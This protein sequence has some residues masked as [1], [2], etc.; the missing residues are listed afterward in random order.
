MRKRRHKQKVDTFP[1]LAVLLCAMGSLILV[2]LVMDRRAKLAAKA[3]VEQAVAEQIAEAA[4]HAEE[5]RAGLEKKRREAQQEWERKREAL[6]ARLTREQEEL[7]KQIRQ[8]RLKLEEAAARLLADGEEYSADTRRVAAEKSRLAGAEQE[9]ANRTAALGKTASEAEATN[10]SLQRMAADLVRAEETLKALK[11]ARERERQ[12]YSVVPYKGRHGESRRPLYIECS[13]QGVI[14]HPDRVTV[15]PGL[16]PT[17]TRAEVDRRVTRQRQAA[18]AHGDPAQATPYLLVLIRPDGIMKYY[19]LQTA[20]RGANVD[21]GYE[22]VDAD[23]VLEFPEEDSVPARPWSTV[24]LSS[25]AAP[26][27]GTTDR[28]RD[29]LVG[30]TPF[31]S[32]PGAEGGGFGN[33]PR[34]ASS[35]AVSGR[36]G[37]SGGLAPP[38]TVGFGDGRGGVWQGGGATGASGPLAGTGGTGVGSSG[39]GGLGTH[40]R[41][42]IGPGAT[43]LAPG[44]N[45]VA[46]PVGS[47]GPGGAAG[48]PDS[49]SGT[50]LAGLG[51]PRRDDGSPAVPFLGHPGMAGAGMP[52][53]ST[54][55]P[56]ALAPSSGEGRG[57]GI[58]FA[59]FPGGNAGN[60]PTGVAGG[61]GTGGGYA[62][63][64]GSDGT[65][66]G[67]GSGN[68]GN[69]GPGR[70]G[71]G[72]GNGPGAIPGGSAGP[73]PGR[74]DTIA[75]RPGVSGV[76]GDGSPGMGGPSLIGGGVGKLGGGVGGTAPG[77]GGSPYLVGTGQ[78][79]TGNGSPSQGSLIT[80][81]GGAPGMG[82]GTS[83]DPRGVPGGTG[84]PPIPGGTGQPGTGS[85]G[86]S[87]A[88]SGGGGQPNYA[89]GAGTVPGSGATNGPQNIASR[90][91]PGGAPNPSSPNG[92][93]SNPN[94][95]QPGGT[96][97]GG[98]PGGGPGPAGDGQVI[99]GEKAADGRQPPP[100]GQTNPPEERDPN[101]P[102]R[103]RP[104][105][106]VHSSGAGGGD[107]DEPSLPLAAPVDLPGMKRR[108]PPPRPAR[109][110]GNRDWIIYIECRADRVVLYPSRQEVALTD[111]RP[112]GD[113]PLVAAVQA[114]IDRRQATV[115]AGDPPYRP[116]VRFLV[117]AENMRAFHFAY[118]ALDTLAV[119]KRRQNLDPEDDILSILTG[120]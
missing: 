36:V 98:P 117:R 51:T 58:G 39:N 111:L 48:P 23:W 118:P 20:L 74:G 83:G 87:E 22:M 8:M 4:R 42:L 47:G 49:G 106:L 89:R 7:Q 119:P 86:G 84:T 56:S 46:G 59:P 38:G 11:A 45:G 12:T 101:A 112:G 44:R 73:F 2:L 50:A 102:P 100:D 40:G 69:G 81:G 19:D 66:N 37:P 31:R 71:P 104:R 114:M 64:N 52:G 105:G 16:F 1:F 116:Q 70:G 53:R 88:G 18:A 67:Y 41:P 94:N 65:A 29:R 6:H 21:F 80:G 109:L 78:P 75:F 24:A 91:Q 108:A 68:S 3:R 113:N 77:S 43:G 76:P 90:G 85:A 32:G 60:S 33:D 15:E 99:S 17:E 82:A 35:G 107:D 97:G 92:P 93:P 96:G 54:G 103:R 13:A 63:A 30:I 26:T 9:L 27:P 57:D 14:F 5:K 55:H 115:P 28:P 72:S 61:I 25:G 62:T 34:S 120:N 10:R 110:R 79:G 95:A